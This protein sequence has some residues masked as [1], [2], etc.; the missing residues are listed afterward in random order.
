MYWKKREL[1]LRII[2][3]VQ[4]EQLSETESTFLEG[5]LM[6]SYTVEWDLVKSPQDEYVMDDLIH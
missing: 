2:P 1:I 5:K 6:P 3:N 4:E